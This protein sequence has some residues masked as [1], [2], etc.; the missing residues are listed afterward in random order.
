MNCYF[1]LTKEN[2]FNLYVPVLLFGVAF[3][4]KLFYI[5]VRDVCIDEPFTIF[6]AQLSLKEILLLPTK[7]EPNPPLFML[8][9]HFWIKLFGISPYSVRII[10]LL[11]NALTPVFIYLTGKK[12]SNFPGGIIAAG[13]F[14]LS[15]YQFYFGI[16]TR[17]YSLL[18]CATSAAI[19]YLFSLIQNPE[20]KVYLAG[21]I[22]SDIALVYC[23]Y[24]GFFVLFT[25]FLTALYYFRN[26]LAL[27]KILIA[28]VTTVISFLP[29][30]VILVKQFF[31]SKKQTWVKPPEAS[32]YW[33]EIV[34]FMN[35]KMVIWITLAL[36][37][38]GI[39]LWL[40]GKQK[41]HF[42]DKIVT[43][44]FF[45]FIPYTLMFFVST[46]V[47]MF[48]NRYVMYNSI[49]LYLFVGTT[50]AFLFQEQKYILW[51]A[52]A[53]VLFLMGFNMQTRR[54]FIAYRE[55]KK[56]VDFVKEHQTKDVL[57]IVYPHWNDYEFAYYYDLK[58][59]K[60]IRNFEPR[61][62]NSL[63]YQVWSLEDAKT[64]LA[65]FK[66]KKIA[67]FRG[68]RGYEDIN[69][70]LDS[71]YIRTDSVSFSDCY[72]IYLYDLKPELR[73]TLSL[74]K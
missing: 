70:Y 32:F 57:T 73:D 36:I 31:L 61:L 5:G 64:Y 47:P 43:L 20:K 71:T 62:H 19:Y 33:R 16:E 53:L 3:V 4:W 66:D 13:L 65:K 44:F 52:S 28:L 6:N 49:G 18:L 74:S 67:Y 27:K 41:K 59:F 34:M 8:I 17:T 24:F 11:F 21:L 35:S 50:V 38:T 42:P 58:I 56:A 25:E 2:I 37:G 14:I 55:T 54:E 7:N 10:P 48:E 40:T 15:S 60:D 30:W 39:L 72:F 45:W 69:R 26:K 63:V 68:G 29:M 12:T 22:L 23:H 51:V 9:L 46:K 1:K